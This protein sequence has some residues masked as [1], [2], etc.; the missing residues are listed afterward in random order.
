M[1]EKA[2]FFYINALALRLPIQSS[3]LKAIINL[4]SPSPK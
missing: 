4:Y 2:A 1:R 3:S